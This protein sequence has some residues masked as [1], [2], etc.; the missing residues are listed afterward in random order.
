MMTGMIRGSFRTVMSKRGLWTLE[1][2]LRQI[3][4]LSPQALA[5]QR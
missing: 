2:V 3:A 5:Q 4:I 1:A